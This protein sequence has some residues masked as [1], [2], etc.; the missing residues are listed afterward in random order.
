MAQRVKN[1]HAM[2]ETEVQSLAQEDPLEK[3]MTT[4]PVLSPGEFHAQRSL[5][6]Y[7]PWGYK[8]LDMTERLKHNTT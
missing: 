4:T 6:E 5:A 8:Q 1:L 7:S 2:E 3:E